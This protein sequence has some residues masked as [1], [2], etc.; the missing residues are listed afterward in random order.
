MTF[1]VA[2]GRLAEID[3]DRAELNHLTAMVRAHHAAGCPRPEF[4]A[5]LAATLALP[6]E[7]VRLMQLLQLALADRAR[8][9]DPHAG[10]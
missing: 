1:S 10:P 6:D 5:G 4:C 3:Q 8:T 2:P 9:P 7:P